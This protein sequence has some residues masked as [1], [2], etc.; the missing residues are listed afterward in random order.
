MLSPVQKLGRQCIEAKMTEQIVAQS[1]LGMA[2]RTELVRPHAFC[3][4]EAVKFGSNSSEAVRRAFR[5]DAV[6]LQVTIRP[7]R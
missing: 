3:G 5:L 7:K 1:S 2:H 4:N 6:Q